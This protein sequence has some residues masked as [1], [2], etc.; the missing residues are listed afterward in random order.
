MKQ[1]ER[2]V[3]PMSNEKRNTYV[4]EHLTNALLQLLEEKPIKEISISELVDK[5]GVGR[6]S[7]YRNYHCKEDIVKRYLY[8]KTQEWKAEWDKNSGAAL[9]R[10]IYIMI[11]HFENNRSFYK[12]LENRGLSYLLKD[13][14]I[15]VCGPKP[16]YDKISAYAAA[17]SAY[18][19]YGWI[20]TWFQ[21]GMQES[22]EEMEEMFKAQGL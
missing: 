7:F 17:F 1:I 12:L 14:I 10:Q 8:E 18:V 22:A 13:V 11:A 21:R 4:I 20:D 9:S 2:S 16:E 15:S 3:S 5:A 6:A 19:L